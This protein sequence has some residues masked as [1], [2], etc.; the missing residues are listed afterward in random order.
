MPTSLRRWDK[1]N[2]PMWASVPTIVLFENLRELLFYVSVF[3]YIEIDMA[4]V[5]DILNYSVD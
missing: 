5:F 4:V 1:I 2:G 3:K